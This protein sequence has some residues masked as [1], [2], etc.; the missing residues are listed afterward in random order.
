MR[1]ER[2][3]ID[4]PRQLIRKVMAVF[5]RPLMM[6][7]RVV[8]VYRK[9]QIQHKTFKKVE[10]VGLWKRSSPIVLLN[11][12][13]NKQDAKPIKRQILITL[14]IICC[15][16]VQFDSVWYSATVG[17]TSVAM[18]FV[19]ADGNKMHGRAI[20]VKTPKVPKDSAFVYPYF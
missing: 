20:P 6:L 11:A 12:K 2:I 8:L 16:F 13:K 5:P 10:V 15:N 7:E 9:G 1:I 18:E 4:I 14:W 19:I 17:R 3:R